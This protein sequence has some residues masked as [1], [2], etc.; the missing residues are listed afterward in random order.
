[1]AVSANNNFFMSYSDGILS[2]PG[3]TGSID[4]AVNMVGWGHD[5]DSGKDYWII[6]NSWGTY[7]GENGYMRIAT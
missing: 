1:M 7:W 5:S 3:C 6:R 4:H 2:N